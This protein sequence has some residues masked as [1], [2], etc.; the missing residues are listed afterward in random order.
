MAETKLAHPTAMH[1]ED[2]SASDIEVGDTIMLGNDVLTVTQVNHY[3]LATHLP[4]GSPHQ[5]WPCLH[6]M[7]PYYGIARFPH[8]PM[9][10]ASEPEAGEVDG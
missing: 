5:P 7:T 3:S 2:V 1:F 4:L 6:I 10:R 9:R 8:E